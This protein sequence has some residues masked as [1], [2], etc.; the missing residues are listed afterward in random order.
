MSTQITTAFVEQYKN[1]VLHL[2]QQKGSRLRDTA[3]YTPVTGKS[4]YFERIC[5]T[6]AQ[7]RTTRHSNT[8]QID[9]PHSRRKVSLVDYDWADLIDQ[10]DKVKMLITPQS[11]YAMAGANAMGRAMDD[12]LIA[13]ATGNAFGGVAGATSIALPTAQKIAGGTTGLTLAK[14]LSAK[15]IIDS[16]DVD[17]EE[18]RYVV[19]SAKQITDLLNTTQVTSSDYN[20]VRALASGQIDTF[21]GFKFIRS[22]RLPIATT[23]RSC[24]AYTESALGLAVGAD[25][26]TRIS[27]RDDKNYATQVFLSMVIGATRIEDEK[28]VEI[29]AKEV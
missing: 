27:E 10:E 22:Q 12:A 1:N 21:L 17:P 28:V 25:I 15:E 5:A 26:T 29:G 3:R 2:A 16:S 8:P 4:H 13:A 19:C 9:T 11:E 23:I 6:A 24:L 20:T 18:A 7:V 14:L